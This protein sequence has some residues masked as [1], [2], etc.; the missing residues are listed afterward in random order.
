MLLAVLALVIGCG[1]VVGAR[2]APHAD[3]KP[4]NPYVPC[5]QWQVEHPGW[6]CFGNFPEIEEP[7]PPP[8]PP[9]SAGPGL[10][11]PAP[12]PA[13]P[14]TTTAP[15]PAAALTPPPAPP[16]DDPC[17]A[18]IPVPDYV[19]PALP[20]NPP[21]APCGH[22]PPTFRELL[23]YFLRTPVRQL[24]DGQYPDGDTLL[25]RVN[26]CV[27][28]DDLHRPQYPDAYGFEDSTWTVVGMERGLG[29]ER[30]ILG[31]D[32]ARHMILDGNTRYDGK[33]HDPRS[34]PRAFMYCMQ[35]IMRKPN[36]AKIDTRTGNQKFV[37][38]YA[39]G[40]EAVMYV[41]PAE[42][43]VRQIRTV[44]T[45]SDP[46]DWVGCAGPSMAGPIR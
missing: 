40:K 45:N 18:I 36:S 24:T 33:I 25:Q 9:P 39:P 41:G 5:S 14:Q 28:H 38:Q 30:A 46:D 27:N 3:A 16:S 15:P 17:D 34:N 1:A 19:P 23:D 12:P 42:N 22:R 37:Y 32:A 20:G 26:A 4:I 21:N 43:G 10:P 11:T 6:P 7:S 31:C 13:S 29:A 2:N 35:N 44:Y 8:T